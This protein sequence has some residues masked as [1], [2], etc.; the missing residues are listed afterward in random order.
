MTLVP[1]YVRVS[2]PVAEPNLTALGVRFRW[3]DE[4]QPEFQYDADTATLWLWAAKINVWDSGLIVCGGPGFL[5]RPGWERAHGIVL[6]HVED[7]WRGDHDP[8]RERWQRL[9]K[10]TKRQ[11]GYTEHL[12]V[13][14]PENDVTRMA[15]A[16]VRPT[17]HTTARNEVLTVDE[18]FVRA[19]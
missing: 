8:K 4:L 3:H 13:R 19:S 6:G 17:F 5:R 7:V 9:R 16:A 12:Y 14:A 2:D 18:R 15:V 10:T 1:L 11:G